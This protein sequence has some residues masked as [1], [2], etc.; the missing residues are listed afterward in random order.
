MGRYSCLKNQVLC[1][2]K[3]CIPKDWT[4][5]G[6]DDCGDRSDESSLVCKGMVE[7]HLILELS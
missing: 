1:T 5:N 7:T 3:K 4:C 6:V 2:N